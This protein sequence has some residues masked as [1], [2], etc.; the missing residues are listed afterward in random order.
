MATHSSVLAWRVPGMEEPGGV[1]SMESHRVRHDWSDSTAAAVCCCCC[2]VDKLCLTLLWAHGLQPARLLCPWDFPIKN[3]GVG[4]NFLLLGIFPTQ[5][6]N[7]H[8]LL[9]RK[10]LYHWATWK[11]SYSKSH[12]K[13]Y[14]LWSQMDV[15]WKPPTLPFVNYMTH[16]TACFSALNSLS[17]KMQ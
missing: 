11:V 12:Y 14:R 2:L 6:S 17:L 3:T 9:G 13:I 4:F 8:L 7:L 16:M 1:P 15:D 5:G 10:V